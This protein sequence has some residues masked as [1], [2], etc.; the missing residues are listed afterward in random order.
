VTST[1]RQSGTTNALRT[2][3][4]C[5]QTCPIPQS[6]AIADTAIRTGLVTARE[7]RRAVTPLRGAGVVKARRV[8]GWV[9]A[10]AASPL[11]SALRGLLLDNG[12]TQ[13]EPQLAVVHEGRRMPRWIWAGTDSERPSVGAGD[14]STGAHPARPTGWIASGDELI[15]VDGRGRRE[16][17]LF[18]GPRRPTRSRRP[19]SSR[20]RA[21]SR[22]RRRRWR[23]S[24]S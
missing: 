14:G 19:A 24:R 7:L 13:F 22:R 15:W 10:R 8:A 9:D 12:F 6:L 16:S 5:A 20:S 17:V 2:V 1:E 11:E 23:P 3:V 4:D 21:R 18:V